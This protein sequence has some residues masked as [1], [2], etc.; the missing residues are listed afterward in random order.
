MAHR[1]PPP[2]RGLPLDRGRP[3]PVG[4]HA[5][6]RP[7]G[8]AA[9]AP[10]DATSSGWRSS[11][12]WPRASKASARRSPCRPAAR[13]GSWSS[14][15]KVSDDKAAAHRQGHR[16]EDQERARLS[17]TDQGHGHPGDEGRGICPIRRIRLAFSSSATSSA[18]RA[19]TRCDGSCPGL[20]AKYRPAFVV[21]NGENAAGGAGHHRRDRPGPA[22][23]VVDVLTGGKPHLGQEGSPRAT[24]TGSRGSCGRRTT[25]PMNP[26]QGR[27]RRDGRGRAEAGRPQ[28]PGPGVHGGD[29]LSVPDG[30]RGGRGAPGGDARRS[31]S[32]STPRRR[33]RSRPWAG[34]WTA[35]S[36]RSS[37]RTPTCRRPTSASCRAGRPTSPTSGWP[38]P[39]NSVIGIQREQAI[40]KFL[41]GRPLRFEPA[42]DGPVPL[43]RLHRDRC[44][45]RGGPCSIVREVAR[46]T[47]KD[48]AGRTEASTVDASLVIRA[49]P[50]RTH[51]QRADPARPAGRSNRAFPAVWVDG[52]D[53]EFPQAHLGPHAI[54]P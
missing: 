51:R 16:G 34:I 54:S 3:R 18:G 37:G 40:L 6:G 29:R 45:R 22:S 21:A 42:K 20:R 52:R 7:A 26:G 17:R 2:R 11:R 8:G 47:L 41:T 4:R 24:S 13:S 50:R 27:D 35:G 5:L 14:R 53:L 38:A 33:R 46:P 36:R 44:R 9:R 43:G 39:G 10:R 30:G 25:R 12:A 49:R 28:P 1:Q 32:I 48:G 19:G 15:H 31:W 23:A